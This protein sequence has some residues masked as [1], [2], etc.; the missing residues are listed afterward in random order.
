MTKM[1]EAR[2]TVSRSEDPDLAPAGVDQ[3]IGTPGTL[4]AATQTVAHPTLALGKALGLGHPAN[5]RN[6]GP[7][8]EKV[9]SKRAGPAR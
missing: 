7:R 1:W 3:S 8:G 6:K 2:R 4:G 9:R 5:Q